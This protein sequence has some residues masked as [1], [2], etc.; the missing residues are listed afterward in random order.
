[1][2]IKPGESL[3]SGSTPIHFVRGKKRPATFLTM[4]LRFCQLGGTAS[5]L[6]FALPEAF[7]LS[8]V[9]TLRAATLVVRRRQFVFHPRQLS[10]QFL[11]DLITDLRHP[12]FD[13][14]E[15]RAVFFPRNFAHLGRQFQRKSSNLGF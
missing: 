4:I 15:R 3:Q 13:G 10:R 7:Q 9:V 6:E 8:G 14:R 2:T 1:L 5:R 11:T 12:N